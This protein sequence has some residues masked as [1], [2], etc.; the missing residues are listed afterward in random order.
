MC[1]ALSKAETSHSL[2]SEVLEDPD[3]TGKNCLGLQKEGELGKEREKKEGERGEGKGRGSGHEGEREGGKK[4]M[5]G[6]V[7]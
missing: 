5:D 2:I 1:W 6:W 7:D 4:G 3:L